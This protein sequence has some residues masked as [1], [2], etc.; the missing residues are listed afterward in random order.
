[1]WIGLPAL[2]VWVR[3]TLQ[4]AGRPVMGG[5]PGAENVPVMLRLAVSTVTLLRLS[6]DCR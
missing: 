2:S 3:V 4:K 5:C 6:C 1:M